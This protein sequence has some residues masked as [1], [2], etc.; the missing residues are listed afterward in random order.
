MER[1]RLVVNK[2]PA[3]PEKPM[4]YAREVAKTFEQIERDDEALRL[5]GCKLVALAVTAIIFTAWLF[6]WHY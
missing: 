3:V 1:I 6:P 4:T 2:P 5:F